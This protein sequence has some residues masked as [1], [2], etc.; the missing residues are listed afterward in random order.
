[1]RRIYLYTIA[2]S[3]AI[4]TL[5]GCER[6]PL[7]DQLDFTALVPVSIDWSLSGVPVEQMHRASVILFP[8]AGPEPLKYY[9]EGDLTY[10]EIAVPVGVYKVL[11]LNETTDP[12]DWEG[13]TFTG[14]DRWETFAAVALPD[15]VRGLYSRSGS[16][17][18][19]KNPD[20]L[21]AW[22]LGRFEVTEEMVTHS[23]D[24]ASTLGASTSRTAST[25]GA[26]LAAAVPDLMEVQPLPRI[27]KLTVLARVTR[28]S[29]AMV[30]TGYIDGMAS[31][32]YMVSGEKINTPGVHTFILNGRVYDQ[33][34][35]EAT[36][37]GTTTRTFN[38]FG[39]MPSPPVV[40]TLNLDFILTDGTLHPRETF[41]VT[42][43]IVPQPGSIPPTST[44][45]V[46]YGTTNGDHLIELPDMRVKAGIGVEDWDEVNIDLKH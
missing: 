5:A 22:S 40:F 46:G 23:R 14:T 29:S 6:R 34:N 7:Y 43:L 36:D 30:S 4:F 13:L 45:D 35:G 1:M 10:R 24:I 32:V 19:I 42:R 37:D 15:A 21:A 8:E 39:R 9:L 2:L 44:I 12:D 26:A 17:P 27:E 3:V 25:R 31:G 18:L 20:P 16:L 41:D 33:A 11:V 28:L 38:I